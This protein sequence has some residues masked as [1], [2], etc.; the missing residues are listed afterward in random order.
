MKVV[1]LLFDSLAIRVVTLSGPSIHRH[2]HRYALRR[3][4]PSNAA[5][6]AGD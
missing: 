6:V 4:L 1:F 3:R 2:P 5:R